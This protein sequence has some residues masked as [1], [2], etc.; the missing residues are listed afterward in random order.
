MARKSLTPVLL[1]ADPVQPLE[2][3]TKQYVDAAAGSGIPP[4]VI[5]MYGG[6]GAPS[7]WLLC[8]ASLKSTTTYAA[9][10]AVIGH[11]F[12]NNVDPGGGQFRLPDI[13]GIFPM[14]AAIGGTGTAIGGSGGSA[15][16]T[17]LPGHMP[18]HQHPAG[19]LGTNNTNSGH[20]HTVDVGNATPGQVNNTL[21]RGSVSTPVSTI[22]APFT[23]GTGLHT[24]DVTG[25]TGN[26]TNPNNAVNVRNPYLAL[27]FIIKT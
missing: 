10:F 8:D 12:N 16:V 26:N 20:V 27:A 14:G 11:A 18:P 1:P 17:L 22:S 13:N 21:Q 2:A 25:S 3:A 23:A 5:Q 4:G 15:T 24:H 7:G 19:T 9:L 6:P